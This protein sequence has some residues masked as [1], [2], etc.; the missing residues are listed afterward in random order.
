M[1]MQI[2]M[3]DYHYTP[4]SIAKFEKKKKITASADE[5]PEQPK[6]SYTAHE[7]TK[8]HRHCI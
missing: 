1:E 8:W 3:M 6:L 2:N 7:H 4:T 5:A